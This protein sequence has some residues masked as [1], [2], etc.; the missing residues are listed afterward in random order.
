VD[1]TTLAT[2]KMSS[3]SAPKVDNPCIICPNGA[4]AGPGILILQT[5]TESFDPDFVDSLDG[6]EISDL[7][8][9]I[10]A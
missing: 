2:T 9:Q 6:E 3:T 1:D 5:N 10:R 8:G 4:T 7:I